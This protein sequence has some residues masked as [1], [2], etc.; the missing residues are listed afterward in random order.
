MFECLE[1]NQLCVLYFPKIPCSSSIA[2]CSTACITL[3]LSSLN[4]LHC[5]YHEAN[6]V[7]V[8][9]IDLLRLAIGSSTGR[10]DVVLDEQL[11]QDMIADVLVLYMVVVM[12][13]MCRIVVVEE[14]VK[15]VNCTEVDGTEVK[16]CLE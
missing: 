5:G 15:T 16:D 14:L 1:L 10:N 4:I 7:L 3:S 11:V 2:L 6:V 12:E 8:N 13:E 9:A